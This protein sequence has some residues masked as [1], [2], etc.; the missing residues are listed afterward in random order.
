MD[1]VSIK[2][3]LAFFLHFVSNFISCNIVSIE[4]IAVGKRCE[5]IFHSIHTRYNRLLSQTIWMF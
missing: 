4:Y 2:D 3:L 1:M 5:H